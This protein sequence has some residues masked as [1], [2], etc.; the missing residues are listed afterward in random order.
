MSVPVLA[1]NLWKS[2]AELIA[3]VALLGYIKQSDHV[4]D[5]TY[6]RGN[7]WTKFRPN[8]LVFH[9]IAQDGI[10]FR[11]LPYN[12]ETFNIVAYDPPYVSIGG[13]KTTTIKGFHDRYGMTD[14]PTSPA[15]L[16][17]LIN[18]GLTEAKRVVQFRGLIL[19]K[20]QDGTY[21]TQRHAI[22]DLSLIQ[23]DRF[24]H[25]GKPRPQPPNRTQ[26]H[27]RRNLSTLFVFQ[28]NK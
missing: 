7:W 20:C 24:E 18:D 5:P 13:R 14:A 6:G 19:V 23:V 3:D 21:L 26:K 25:I 2:N 1:A 12:N 8:N 22:E 9:D 10:D 11:K 15:L 17:A 4:L 16:Q 28:K 27:A